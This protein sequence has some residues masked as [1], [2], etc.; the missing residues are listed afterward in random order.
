MNKLTLK[1]FR[2]LTEGL[3]ED[4]PIVYHG[5]DEGICLSNYTV[6]DFWLFPKDELKKT[7]VVL[8][9][10]SDYDGRSSRVV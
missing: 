6:E 1:K 9:P 3:P 4:T 2:E 8:N 10:A 7:L 5:F